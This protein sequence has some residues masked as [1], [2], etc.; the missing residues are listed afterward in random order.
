MDEK[1][2]GVADAF[3][4]LVRVC[5]LPNPIGL[6]NRELAISALSAALG[7]EDA[8]LV[9]KVAEALRFAGQDWLLRGAPSRPSS[10][11]AREPS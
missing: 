1:A 2:Q 11:G 7:A 4:L 3:D 9:D 8:D 5:P 10:E 6:N